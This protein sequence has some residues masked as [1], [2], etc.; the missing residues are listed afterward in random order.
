[1]QSRSPSARKFSFREACNYSSSS[2]SLT[3]G[4]K[5]LV[6]T[7]LLTFFIVVGSWLLPEWI[8]VKSMIV[9]YTGQVM[10]T[11]GWTQ[12]WALFCPEVRDLNYHL[13]ALIEYS[14]G[15]IK[16]YEFPRMEK[17]D[18]LTKFK[19]EK[20]RKLFGDNISWPP[21]AQFRP[22]VS[23][24]LARANN[25][26]ANPPERVTMFL[27]STNTPPPDPEHWCYRDELPFHTRKQVLFSYEVNPNDLK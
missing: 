20:L 23:R 5:A 19:R 11:T 2:G 27:N 17:M 4:H 14:D 25:D 13:A 8:P 22:S 7:F 15:T 18:L 9:P 6:S 16:C 21:Y 3:S 1:M 12:W 26:P 10:L 24:Y